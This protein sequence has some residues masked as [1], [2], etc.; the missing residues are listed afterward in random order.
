VSEFSWFLV[1]A[2]YCLGILVAFALIISR[3][4]ETIREYERLRDEIPPDI[5][6]GLLALVWP[7]IL[8]GFIPA[9][10]IWRIL[11]FFYRLGMGEIDFRS[12]VRLVRGRFWQIRARI[13]REDG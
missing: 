4:R 3:I 13:A 9:L 7:V 1:W 6:W 11:Q 8:F 10:L 12:P 5:L 2:L